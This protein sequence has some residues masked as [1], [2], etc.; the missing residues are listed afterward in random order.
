MYA[1]NGIAANTHS[2]KINKINLEAKK[3]QTTW[4]T[5]DVDTTWLDAPGILVEAVCKELASLISSW[6]WAN[7]K[8]NKMYI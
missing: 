6:A 2:K 3:C 8:T 5:C 1:L 4:Q 7:Y